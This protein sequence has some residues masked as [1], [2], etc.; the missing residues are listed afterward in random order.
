MAV[1]AGEKPIVNLSEYVVLAS[2]LRNCEDQSDTFAEVTGI[3]Y[4]ENWHL[5]QSEPFKSPWS[6]LEASVFES[7]PLLLRLRLELFEMTR[8]DCVFH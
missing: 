7:T 1:A 8:K 2:P 4:R 3:C 5:L 6:N